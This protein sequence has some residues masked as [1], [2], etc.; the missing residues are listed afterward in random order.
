MD[1]R[2]IAEQ[3]YGVAESNHRLAPLAKE[4]LEVIDQ[5]LDTHGWVRALRQLYLLFLI[6]TS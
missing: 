5:C 6:L 1:C 3:V 4:A 2:K